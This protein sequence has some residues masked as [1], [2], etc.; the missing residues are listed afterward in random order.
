M[1]RKT[2]R[3]G[4][5]GDLVAVVEHLGRMPHPVTQPVPRE[6]VK[7][8]A[9][10]VHAHPRRLARDQDPRTGAKPDHRARH[11]GGGGCSKTRRAKTA[12]GDLRGHRG[13]GRHP[14]A[15]SHRCTGRL[16]NGISFYDDRNMESKPLPL[17]ELTLAATAFAALGSEPRLAILRR[18]VRAG[19]VGLPIGDLGAAVGVT[20]S[21]LTHHLRQLVSAGMVR[22][23]RD[24]RRILC[25][26]DHAAV[27]ALSRFLVAE[28]CADMSRQTPCDTEHDLG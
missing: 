6:I 23:K 26:V 10:S 5:D 28:C 16:D 1:A 17:S 3:H 25:R 8:P 14:N 12:G 18:L 20:G 22:Q 2:K 9:R 19:P 15:A 4:N 21:V 11:M 27:A 13:Y 7:R 24:G